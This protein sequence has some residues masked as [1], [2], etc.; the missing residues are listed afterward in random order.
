M[1]EFRAERP[2]YNDSLELYGRE[3]IDGKNYA[4]VATGIERREV[5]NHELWPKFLS[6]HLD[7]D[8]GQSLFQA[9]WDAGYRPKNGETSIAHVEALKYH[10]EDMRKLVFKP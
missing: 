2:I 7:W 5:K 10:L 1:I 8:C 6:I 9:L 3:T 4:L